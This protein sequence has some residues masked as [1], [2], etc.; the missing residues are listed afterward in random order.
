MWYVKLTI[1]CLSV[2]YGT[3]SSY[4]Y[5]T[6][7]RSDL[8]IFVP[9]SSFGTRRIKYKVYGQLIAGQLIAGQLSADS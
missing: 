8:H 4:Y 3:I 6:R 7:T 2:S 5:A 9:N 1:F